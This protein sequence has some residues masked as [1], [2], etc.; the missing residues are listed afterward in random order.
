MNI[1]FETLIAV[2][3]ELLHEIAGIR[4]KILMKAGVRHFQLD[5]L[6]NEGYVGLRAAAEKYDPDRGKEFTDFARYYIN[7]AI[8]H[9]LRN[10]DTIDHR[11]RKKIKT[12]QKTEEKLS[13]TLSREPTD[14]EIAMELNLST[15]KLTELRSRNIFLSSLDDSGEKLDHEGRLKTEAILQDQ[16]IVDEDLAKATDDCM[17]K[18]LNKDEL[19]IVL[20]NQLRYFSANDIEKILDH[21]YNIQKIYRIIHQAGSKLKKCIELKGWEVTDLNPF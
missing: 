2:H 10:E 19:F 20:L 4:H 9:F 3:F 14:K 8:S 18:V 17:K 21:K 5:E 1:D 12:M 13:Q 6:I 16:R 7:N 11:Q 15:D